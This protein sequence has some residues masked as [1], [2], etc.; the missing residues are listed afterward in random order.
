MYIE[1]SVG[2]LAKKLADQYPVIAITG[3][4]QS[5][6]T[7]LSKALFTDKPYVSLEDIDVREYAQEDPRDFINQY[8]EG[9]VLDEVQNVPSL[10]SY[11]QTIVDNNRKPGQFILTGSQ[12][13]G[14]FSRIT[15]SLS[16][17]IALITLLPFSQCELK[18]LE[19]RSRTIDQVLFTGFYPPIYD[20]KLEPGTWYGN[21]VR[22]YLERDVRKMVNVR[23][24]SA[25]QRFLRLCSG[26]IGQ[27]VNFSSLANDCGITHNTARAW[28]SILEAS[29]IIR[30]LQPHY[31]NFNKRLIKSPKMYFYDPG[32]AVWL[33]GIREPEQLRLHPMRGALFESLVVSECLKYCYN[34]G[35]EPNL[36]FWRD[37]TG[38]EI[39]V[40]IDKGNRLI[41]L[42]I[43]SG[44]TISG[45]YFRNIFYWRKL[46]GKPD[47]KAWLIYGGESGQ[48]RSGI[49]ALS[50]KKLMEEETLQR[51]LN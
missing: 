28:I 6:K 38:N 4:R 42:E 2:F 44:T 3:P 48:V 39:D 8:P 31:R 14:L 40:I 23:D 16:G 50:W 5:G 19:S 36:Y 41:P 13:F 37:R 12:Q 45:D 9:A 22:T 26:R 21:Y 7:T 24:L 18:S 11:I 17:R 49:E 43:K 46:S 20:R 27:L 51:M 35:L 1:R 25:F 30:L 33:L 32:L 47:E 10:F 29:F 15:Q 34:S